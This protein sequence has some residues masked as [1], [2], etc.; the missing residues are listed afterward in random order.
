MVKFKAIK[1]SRLSE[2]ILSQLREAILRGQFKAGEKLPSERELTEQFRVSRG[3]VREAIRVLENTGFVKIRHGAG[4][5]AY[6]T[7]LTFRSLGEGFLD[8]F[9]ANKLTISELIQ[10]RKHIEPEV[11]RLAALRIN[12]E[13]RQKLEKALEQE[14]SPPASNVQYMQRFTHVHYILAEMCGNYIF[15]AIVNSMFK[16]THEILT[17][18][19]P[20]DLKSMHGEGDHDPIVEAVIAGDPEAAA[21]AMTNHLNEFCDELIA[22]DNAYRGRDKM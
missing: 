1:Q 14:K 21:R 13:H 6:V 12:D 2:E 3:A 8:L 9:L 11:A 19:D 10:A 4:G 20:M 7:E 18:I 5:G 17:A 16:L 15:E 22:V